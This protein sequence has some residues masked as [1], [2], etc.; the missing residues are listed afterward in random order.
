MFTLFSN[1]KI[2]SN[3]KSQWTKIKWAQCGNSYVNPFAKKFFFIMLLF[4]L[5]SFILNLIH[6]FIQLHKLIH[7]LESDSPLRP[8][9]GCAPARLDLAQPARASTI[10]KYRCY[11]MGTWGWGFGA[12]LGLPGRISKCYCSVLLSDAAKWWLV[13]F[14]PFYI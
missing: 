9:R 11:C 8:F 1:K 14:Y 3:R 13:F 7:L 12:D 10:S 6:S 5:S 4:V 2:W